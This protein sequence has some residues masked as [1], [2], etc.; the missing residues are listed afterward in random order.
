MVV[1]A[2]PQGFILRP[3]TVA[4]RRSIARLLQNFERETDRS[5]RYWPGWGAIAIVLWSLFSV[6]TAILLLA[7]VALVSAVLWIQISSLIETDW[8][9]Y[10]VIADRAGQPSGKLV[11]CAKLCR[12]R[13]YSLLF[14]LLI[15]PAY[16][17]RGLGSILVMTLSQRAVK[18]LYLACAADRVSFYTRLGF[19]H[20]AAK[21]LSAILRNDLGITPH[22]KL[23]VLKL[24]ALDKP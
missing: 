13:H 11:A 15:A 8:K 23:L 21:E 17:D 6:S 5:R 7:I 1:P 2:L 18:P 22:S 20:V 9:Q 16:R 4:D 12:Y 24:T 19:Q 3:A 14:N 10:W